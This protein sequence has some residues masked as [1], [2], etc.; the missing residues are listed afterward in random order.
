MYGE[1]PS[2]QSVAGGSHSN[3][4]DRVLRSTYRKHSSTPL[5]PALSSSTPSGSSQVLTSSISS[6]PLQP[7]LSSSTPSGSSQVLTSSISSTP[8]QPVLS[9]STPSGSSQ[10]LTSSI[11]ST[12]LQPALSSSTPSSSSHVLRSSIRTTS[13]TQQTK[14]GLWAVFSGQSHRDAYGTPQFPK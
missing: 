1:R 12:P 8:L 4:S 5:Q 11:S 13:G 10:V 2:K 6:T 14:P 7:V 9:S 3:N